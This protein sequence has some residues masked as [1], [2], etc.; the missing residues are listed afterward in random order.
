[1]ALGEG[2]ASARSTV[3]ARVVGIGNAGDADRPELAVGGGALQA[4][5]VLQAERLETNPLARPA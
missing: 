5:D 2:L 1:V 3:A 4:L